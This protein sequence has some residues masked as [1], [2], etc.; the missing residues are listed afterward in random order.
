MVL[1]P[2]KMVYPTIIPIGTRFGTSDSTEGVG[3]SPSKTAR[4]IDAGAQGA[5]QV[6]M[7]QVRMRRSFRGLE[8]RAYGSPALPLIAWPLRLEGLRAEFGGVLGACI[9][10]LSSAAKRGRRAAGPTDVGPPHVPTIGPP[11]AGPANAAAPAACGRR[12]IHDHRGRR[13]RQER[14]STAYEVM[15]LLDVPKRPASSRMSSKLVGDGRPR[16]SARSGGGHVRSGPPGL[17]ARPPEGTH[18]L[19]PGPRSWICAS[20]LHPGRGVA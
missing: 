4:K 1:S 9:W 14:A 5:P 12:E 17:P 16:I 19:C 7:S 20:P 18:I 13:V 8:R 15:R 2:A 3:D 6:K 10:S 11:I